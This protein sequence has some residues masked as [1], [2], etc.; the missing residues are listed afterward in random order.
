MRFR[1]KN[2]AFIVVDDFICV[3][4]GMY[5]NIEDILL[6]AQRCIDNETVETAIE[7]RSG[8]LYSEDK[9]AS[10]EPFNPL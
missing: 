2:K 7:H 3:S 9:S 5:V 6:A 1:Y 4:E 10:S 8:K